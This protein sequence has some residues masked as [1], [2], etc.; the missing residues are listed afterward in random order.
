MEK[1][2]KQTA[3]RLDMLQAIWLRAD[4][5]GANWCHWHGFSASKLR[6]LEAGLQLITQRRQSQLA[7][8]L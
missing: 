3:G 5:A 2:N 4:G 1:K 6:S 7:H 8:H